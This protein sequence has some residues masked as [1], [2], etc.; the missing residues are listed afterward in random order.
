MKKG[1]AKYKQETHFFLERSM[2]AAS[3]GGRSRTVISAVRFTFTTL[4]EGR[5]FSFFSFDDVLAS[6]VVVLVSAGVDS[7]GGG[8]ECTKCAKSPQIA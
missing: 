2:S 6:E 3:G 4:P 1:P 8:G 7:G 5:A